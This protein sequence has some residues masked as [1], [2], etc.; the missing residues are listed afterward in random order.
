MLLKIL[1]TAKYR[2]LI[3]RFVVVIKIR[4]SD[5]NVHADVAHAANEWDADDRGG[6]GTRDWNTRGYTGIHLTEMSERK[7]SG[8]YRAD[9]LFVVNC[10]RIKGEGTIIVFKLRFK[11]WL[12]FRVRLPIVADDVRR[13]IDDVGVV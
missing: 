8:Q 6:G 11:L 4:W 9:T 3:V 13:A 5:R 1:L 10:S 7:D 12:K 2:S